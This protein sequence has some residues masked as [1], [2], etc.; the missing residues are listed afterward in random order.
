VRGL[1][2]QVSLDGG[3]HS[4]IGILD[5]NQTN[6]H[7]IRCPNGGV[8]EGGFDG[9]FWSRA[10]RDATAL[11]YELYPRRIAIELCCAV[12]QNLNA[13]ASAKSDLGAT[14]GANR[15]GL[16]T[17]DRGPRKQRGIPHRSGLA[18]NDRARNLRLTPG[19]GCKKCNEDSGD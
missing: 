15:N 7:G 11:N 12:V 16:A 14:R 3:Q 19:G 8:T 2:C 17:E 4:G 6:G 18:D 5:V 13:T 9:F 1:D 10:E